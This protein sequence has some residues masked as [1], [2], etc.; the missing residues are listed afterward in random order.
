M[1][2]TRRHYSAD[3]RDCVDFIR[4]LKTATPAAIGW[5]NKLFSE[6]LYINKPCPADVM[7]LEPQ[8]PWRQRDKVFIEP[9]DIDS[10][11][12]IP[13]QTAWQYSDGDPTNGG[14]EGKGY[15][16][17]HDFRPLCRFISESCKIDHSYHGKRIGNCTQ[18]FEWYQFEW[19]WW[20]NKIPMTQSMN[21]SAAHRSQVRS[22]TVDSYRASAYWRA[23]LI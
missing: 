3:I 22:W 12:L 11:L 23:I 18:A 8:D 7:D 16:K 2:R 5:C 15:E 19:L 10:G 17:N 20:I 6:G 21:W 13:Y 9:C 4:H 14:V 1:I